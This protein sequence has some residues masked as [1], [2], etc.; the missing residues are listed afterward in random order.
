MFDVKKLI[1]ATQ[2][3]VD[4]AK[5]LP[6]A[7][8][9]VEYLLSAATEEEVIIFAA[10]SSAL[11]H[12]VL[13]PKEN[14]TPA[15][16][17]DLIN[18]M[19]MQDST[20]AIT[21]ASGGGQPNRVYL[22][23]PFEHPGCKSLIGSEFLV[24]RRSFRSVDKGKPRTEVSQKL[25]HALDLYWREEEKAYCRL[26]KNGDIEPVLRV[27][28]LERQT[29]RPWDILVTIKARDLARYMVLTSTVLVT[30]FDFTRIRLGSFARWSGTSE[31]K[32]HGSDL[33]YTLQSQADGSYANGILISRPKVEYDDLLREFEWP[34]DTAAKQYATFKAYDWKNDR[35]DEIS[36]APDALAS[37]FEADSPLP[38]QIT[39]AFFRPEVLQRYKA[40]PEK[41]SLEHRSISS[42]AGWSLQT[43]DVN[44]AGQVHTYLRYLG[45]LPYEE[46]LYWKSFNEWPKG[47]ISQ[48]AFQT[49][50][51]GKWTDIPD[52]L[53][54][55]G[56]KVRKLD[57]DKPD[58]WSTRGNELCS[59]IHY[60]I[61]TS[62]E[63]W[64]NSLLILDQ[65]LVEGFLP[66]P[67]RARLRTFNRPFEEQWASLRLIQ[68][69]IA[70][71]GTAESE[72]SNA[73]EPL[74]QLHFLRSKVKGHANPALREV[75]I[76]D[77]RTEH[78]SL[79]DHFRQLAFSCEQAFSRACSSL[80]K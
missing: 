38:F 23:P 34:E 64:A 30:K 47:P 77:A 6:N 3:G 26:D 57:E 75:L 76:Q 12:G 22:A 25:V 66:K 50:F 13:A 15:D 74:R 44:D 46:Q 68:E 70:A 49:D 73:V 54:R 71:Q 14:V 5:W 61:T 11:V 8:D 55:L 56:A 53:V 36:C 45:Y 43:Y 16:Q 24:V 21:H 28:D 48:R 31:R 79:K 20:W 51:E 9:S 42:R 27:V 18:A 52:P 63:E 40:D 32:E 41:Y 80:E 1:A 65:I 72:A 60:P 37:Y 7:E 19:F 59:I 2:P 10:L 78:G 62:P 58:W 39:P 67:I 33:F 35:T 4:L 17:D 29:G 69:L